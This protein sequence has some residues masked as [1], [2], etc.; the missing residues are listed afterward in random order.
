MISI[1]SASEL[2]RLL[3]GKVG[4]SPFPIFNSHIRP[5][6]SPSVLSGQLFQSVV[7]G[8][9]A[10]V[11][12]LPHLRWSLSHSL[13]ILYQIWHTMSSFFLRLICWSGRES[14]PTQPIGTL[15][16][17]PFLTTPRLMERPLSLTQPCREKWEGSQLLPSLST[18]I[19]PKTDRNVKLFSIFFYFI[20]KTTRGIVEPPA[21]S[22]VTSYLPYDV[23][24]LQFQKVFHVLLSQRVQKQSVMD[25]LQS[26]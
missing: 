1:T 8:D 11:L 5:C 20:L 17:Y 10:H 13:L 9:F 21:A 12:T 18:Y 23:S 14:N 25:F 22:S 6:L 7:K 4:V 15:K 3:G 16:A 26:W 19:I 2:R 24:L